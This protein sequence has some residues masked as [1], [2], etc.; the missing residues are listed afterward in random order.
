MYLR[1]MKDKI[2]LRVSARHHIKPQLPHKKHKVGYVDWPT[3]RTHTQQ[4]NIDE[5]SYCDW[6]C[7][8]MC[9]HL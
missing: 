8:V 6:M 1:E 5:H 2:S 9:Y 4:V 3:C 7:D